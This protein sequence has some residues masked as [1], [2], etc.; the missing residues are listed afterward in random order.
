MMQAF[1]S[2]NDHEKNELFNCLS[3]VKSDPYKEYIRFRDSFTKLIAEK[4]IPKF[5]VDI[6][7]TIVYER[8]KLKKYDHYITN[9]PID[10]ELPI[11]DQNNPVEDK[12]RRKNTYI[13][14]AL[15]ELFS[16]STQ[17]P[18][19]GYQTRNNGD[20]FHDVYAQKKYSNTQTQKTDGE[21]FFHNDRTAHPVRADYLILLGMRCTENNLI[22]TGYI[23]GRHLLKYLSKEEQQIL[24]QKYFVTPFDNYSRDSNSSQTISDRHVILENEHS[25]R[26][27]DTRTN[28]ADES[29]TVAK[30][31][32]IS[33]KNAIVK[34]DKKRV[35]LGNGDLLCIPNQDGLHNR[36]R[37]EVRDQKMAS[38][39]WLLK[40][41]NFKSIQKRDIYTSHYCDNIPGLVY[42]EPESTNAMAATM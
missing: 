25:F 23:D 18:L 38:I 6:C 13:G 5:F 29:P 9:C 24:R 40:T 8:T 22:Y 37:I 16:Q 30:D 31:A 3:K 7:E 20:F 12:Y 15:L 4:E 26:Y 10:K 19:L 35:R 28:V 34:S 36:E 21:L 32:L 17:L 14:E 1:F 11:F 39:R 42:D 2:F 27:Y 33:L 41:Y